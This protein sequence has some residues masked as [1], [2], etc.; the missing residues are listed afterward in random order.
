MDANGWLLYLKENY[1]TGSTK[2]KDSHLL[3]LGISYRILQGI[4]KKIYAS[5]Y[6]SFLNSN[7]HEVYEMD[8]IQTKV[9]GLIQDVEEASRA[10]DQ[11]IPYAKE[12]SLVDS[13]C[14]NFKM[15]KTYPETI[16]QRLETLAKSDDPYEQRIVAVMILSH[17]VNEKYLERII[18]L[19]LRLRIDHYYTKM[20]IAWAFQVI[21]VRYKEEV[22]SVFSNS[23]LQ[24]WIQNKAI[25]KINESFRI[26]DETKQIFKTLRIN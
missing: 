16:F 24:P 3:C 20:A 7:P 10:F 26:S 17:F 19:L 2:R 9:I 14:Q 1:P 22:I 23:V 13:L 15:A 11:F 5:D 21:A 8:I 12:W 18:D 25:Q 4:A 6:K